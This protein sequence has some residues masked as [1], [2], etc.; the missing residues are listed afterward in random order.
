MSR[1][2]SSMSLVIGIVGIVGIVLTVVQSSADEGMWTFDNP[3]RAQWRD[4]YGF[5]PSSAWLD[6]LRLSSVRL[7][8]GGSAAFVSSDGLRSRIST[9]QA[10]SS[11]RFRQPI[12]TSLRKAFG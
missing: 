1:L 11:R 4:R 12:E 8:D 9:W 7:N 3:P 5:D 10:D 6:H 2:R